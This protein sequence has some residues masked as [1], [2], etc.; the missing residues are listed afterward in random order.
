[1]FNYGKAAPRGVHGEGGRGGGAANERAAA[2]WCRLKF[3]IDSSFFST[4][5]I[6]IVVL[7]SG[8]LPILSSFVDSVVEVARPVRRRRS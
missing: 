7:L 8:R 4:K 1:M 6:F 3:L 2:G 5:Q